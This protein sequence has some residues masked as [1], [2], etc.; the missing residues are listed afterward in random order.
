MNGTIIY[1]GNFEL[2]NK[3]VA[4]LRVTNNGKL[5]SALGYNVVYLGTAYGKRFS[6][7]R[8]S[9][10]DDNIYE[11]AYPQGLQHWIKHIYQT[12]NIETVVSQYNDTFLIITY[13]V[14]F[15]T[16]KAIKKVFGR[17]KIRVAYDCTEWN[18]Y[19]EGLFL[20]GLYKKHD[21]K[22]IRTRLH[23]I[24]DNIIVISSL[25][26]RQYQE[27][28]L[29]KLPPLVDIDDPI[30]HQERQNNP[31][32]FE[33]CFAGS[34]LD[35]TIAKKEKLNEVVS[36]FCEIDNPAIR[37]KVVG[38]TSEDYCKAYPEHETMALK[39][40]RISFLGNV[41][42]KDSVWH[43]INCDCYIFI[44]ESSR[45]NN[46]GFPTKFVESYTC[47]VPIITTDVSD[48]KTYADSDV[49]VLD[50]ADKQSITAAMENII[51][52]KKAQLNLKMTFDYHEFINSSKKW[53]TKAFD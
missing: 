4:A 9:S 13:N 38:L 41:A 11:E 29:L 42:H 26:E 19:S 40:N 17:K 28:N 36:A 20:K 1:V 34:N 32:I 15:A 53:F 31:D 44:R 10:Y 22:Q 18:D 39:D 21:E 30:W 35:G 6:G 50:T 8:R 46:A 5:F 33:F 25:M 48:I 2:P 52:N 24:C 27:K 16:Y 12:D 43:V 51:S 49:T 45:R 3:N 23:T 7:V 14:P 37:L 47:G